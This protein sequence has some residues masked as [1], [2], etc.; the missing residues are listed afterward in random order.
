MPLG[1]HLGN[2]SWQL[3]WT[4]KTRLLSALSLVTGTYCFYTTAFIETAVKYG[5]K[6]AE[7]V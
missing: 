2:A 4:D 7:K 6:I 5:K 1:R 3:F